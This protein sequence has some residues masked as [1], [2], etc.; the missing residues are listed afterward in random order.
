MANRKR[1][2][3]R[4]REWRGTLARFARSGLSAREFCRREG[5]QEPAFYFWR[6]TLQARDA[7]EAA[8]SA[9]PAFLPV[10]VRR[11]EQDPPA[12]EV[13]GGIAIDLGADVRIRCSGSVSPEYIAALVRALR[14]EAGA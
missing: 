14:T 5:V 7:E 8:R 13:A 12:A 4:E 9:A 1:N 2:E 6:R 11:V 3:R 10:E